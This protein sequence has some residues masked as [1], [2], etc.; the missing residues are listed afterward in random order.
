MKRYRYHSKVELETVY[1]PFLFI[2]KRFS[3]IVYHYQILR[4]DNLKHKTE[5]V[6]ETTSYFSYLYQLDVYKYI[7]KNEDIEY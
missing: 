5:V 1:K 2:F 4:K 6:F 7:Y 3:H